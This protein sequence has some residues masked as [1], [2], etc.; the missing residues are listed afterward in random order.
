MTMTVAR[1]VSGAITISAAK[2]P[3]RTRVAR[4][5]IIEK[6]PGASS[7]AAIAMFEFA[8]HTVYSTFPSL[9]RN[10]T[11]RPDRCPERLP[12]LFRSGLVV[13]LPANLLQVGDDVMARRS[14]EHTNW[15]SCSGHQFL[16][17]GQPFVQF[18][19]GPGEVSVL[20]R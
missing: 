4:E 5:R 9:Y 8:P 1:R 3:R 19:N 13:M 18:I 7:P 11:G 2:E 6:R 15:H 12:L 17:A 14:I 10:P 20:Q 16:G